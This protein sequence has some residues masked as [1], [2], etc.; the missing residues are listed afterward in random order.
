MKQIFWIIALI[1]L[2][3]V[4]DRFFG[5]LLNQLTQK[6][7]FR[8]SRLYSGKAE[9][10]I[11]LLGNSR[12][13]IFFQPYIEEMTGKRTFNFSYNGLPIE[14][15]K[16]LVQDYLDQYEAPQSLIIDVSM[17]DRSNNSLVAG[18]NMFT[19]YSERVDQLIQDSIPKSSNAGKIF[20]LY[21]YNSEIFQ[22]TLYHYGI[23]AT[24]WL[25]D[26][27]INDYMVQEVSNLAPYE[28]DLKPSLLE[29]LNETIRYALDKNVEVH[30]VI[31]PYYPPFADKITN[32]TSFKNRIQNA[33]GRKVHDYS[34]AVNDVNGFGDYQHLNKEGSRQFLELLQKDGILPK[35]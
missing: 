2:I 22:R 18:F 13:L 17:C 5:F 24:D 12:G 7:Q 3:F 9:S 29:A 10:D 35:K 27:K 21:R 19:P 28:I 4:G 14:L 34:K 20:H 1:V 11:L 33:T 23:P 15:G 25:L 6:S 31:N 30:L 32:L 16:T 8:Y 26:R